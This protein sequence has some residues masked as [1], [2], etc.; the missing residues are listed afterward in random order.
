MMVDTVMRRKPVK[1]IKASISLQHNGGPMKIEIDA[2]QSPVPGLVI[3]KAV[4]PSADNSVFYTDF[5]AISHAATGYRILPTCWTLDKM[6]EA[7]RVT[8]IVQLRAPDMDWTITDKE[9][10]ERELKRKGIGPII[11][12]AI[13]QVKGD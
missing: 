2:Y 1:R 3:H 11:K 13:N 10:M 7:E 5:W 12:D 8:R 4:Y 6:R 9:E